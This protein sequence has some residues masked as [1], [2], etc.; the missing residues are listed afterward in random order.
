MHKINSPDK[1]EK[2]FILLK[3]F[4]KKN[5]L[6]FG[7]FWEN[8]KKTFNINFIDGYYYSLGKRNYLPFVYNHHKYDKKKIS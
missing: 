4:V 3:K 1:L 7:P 8:A 5:N 2:R 6:K